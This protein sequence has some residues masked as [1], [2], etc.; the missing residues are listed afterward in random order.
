MMF[1]LMTVAC[2]AQSA[3][4]QSVVKA[5]EIT[6]SMATGKAVQIRNVVIDGDLDF[7]KAGN[8]FPV[9]SAVLETQIDGNV[10]FEKCV[11]KGNVKAENVRFNSNLIFL[12]NEFQ[13]EVQF[14][15]SSVFGAVNFS[16]SVFKGNAV[17]ASMAVW[18]KNSYFSEVKASGNF[19]LEASDFHGNLSMMNSEFAGPF[20]LQETFVLGHLQGSNSK[21]NGSTDFSLLNVLQRTIFRYA[22]FKNEPDFSESKATVEK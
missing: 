14:Q 8:G 1:I 9:N 6:K 13:K 22:G 12:E 10:Y 7:S 3:V 16:K 5:D 11:F 15:N 4:K 21:F 19:S 20:S 18:A 2:S 17:F